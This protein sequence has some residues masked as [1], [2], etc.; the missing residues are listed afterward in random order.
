MDHGGGG[1][2][3]WLSLVVVGLGCRCCRGSRIG[4]VPSTEAEFLIVSAMGLLVSLIVSSVD[5]A[6]VIMSS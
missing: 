3:W 2:V 4:N 5:K 1:G 6:Y